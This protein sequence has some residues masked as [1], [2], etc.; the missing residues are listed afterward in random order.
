MK[1]TITTLAIAAILTGCGSKERA[2]SERRLAEAERKLE[3]ATKALEEAQKAAG[4]NAPAAPI[5]QQ[6]PEP[7]ALAKAREDVKKQAET[8]ASTAKSIRQTTPAEKKNDSA[9]QAAARAEA[10]AEEARR[11]AAPPVVHTAAAGTPIR[12]RTT[13]QIST[14]TAT[15]GSPFEASLAEPLTVDGYVIAPRGA[16]VEGVVTDSDDGGRVKGKAF[17]SLSLRTLTTADGRKLNIRTDTESATAKGGAK[18]DALKVGIASGIGAAIGAIA[19]GGKGAAIGAGAGAAGGTGVVLATKGNA[20]VIP[21]ES[22]LTFRLTA[23]VSVEE[24]RR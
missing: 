24:R 2:E 14:K 23:P 4:A 3:E 17:I 6:A 21:A 18:K 9:E 20:A 16:S 12:I 19:G 1:R 8:V 7:P 5:P 22:L 15:A 13:T 10:K 11:I